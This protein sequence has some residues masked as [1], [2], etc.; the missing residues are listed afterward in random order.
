MFGAWGVYSGDQFFAIIDNSVVYVKN[1]GN[2][3]EIL[4][5]AGGKPFTWRSKDGEV[6]TMA[7]TS[8]ADEKL[9]DT[10]FVVNVLRE[11]LASVV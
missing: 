11:I 8:I 6:H 10:N 3:A 1:L 9:E 5:A 4:V 2:V 7:Y